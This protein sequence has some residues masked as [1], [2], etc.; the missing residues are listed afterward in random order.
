MVDTVIDSAYQAVVADPNHFTA[1]NPKLRIE[2][3]NEAPTG[4]YQYSATPSTGLEKVYYLC[5][6]ASHAWTITWNGGSGP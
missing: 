3:N 2:A 6:L 5:H 1:V 4:T